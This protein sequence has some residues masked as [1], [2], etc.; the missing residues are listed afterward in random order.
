MLDAWRDGIAD[1]KANQ[2]KLQQIE[3]KK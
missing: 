3:V 2:A 1:R